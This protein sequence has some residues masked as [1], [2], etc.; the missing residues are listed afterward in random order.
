M[1]MSRCR[2]VMRTVSWTTH[3]YDE[4]SERLLPA[5]VQRS[6]WAM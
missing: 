5:P 6:V 2:T 4:P 1:S 3:N